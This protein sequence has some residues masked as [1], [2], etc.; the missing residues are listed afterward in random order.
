MARRKQRPE[1]T[2]GG[3]Y[4]LPDGRKVQ[5]R[6]KA[7]RA[8]GL[9]PA[10]DGNRRSDAAR[11]RRRKP[12]VDARRARVAA[13][14]VRRTPYRQISEALG[15]SLATVA[16]DVSEIRRQWRA[17]AYGDV[18]DY[19]LDEL[20]V[21][22]TDEFE[23]RLLYSRAT[24]ADTKMRIYDRVSRIMQRRAD[25][26]GL[27]PPTVRKVLIS[28]DA[29]TAAR[30][31]VFVAGGVEEDYLAAVYAAQGLTPDRPLRAVK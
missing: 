1:P 28:D 17:D 3:W 15:V 13:L 9:D 4:R 31:T 6:E 8:A 18:A 22:D 19:V 25:L 20:R 12:D 21:L 10:V 7:Y 29:E 14:L 2:G 23:L 30:K 27:D 16:A 5:G 24:D 11:Q 26:L